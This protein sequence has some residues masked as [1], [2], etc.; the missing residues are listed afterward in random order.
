MEPPEKPD[1]NFYSQ[2]PLGA[3]GAEEGSREL[4]NTVSLK[5]PNGTVIE[6]DRIALSNVSEHFN[7]LFQDV[8]NPLQNISLGGCEAIA[9]RDDRVLLL[10]QLQSK[11]CD[12]Q[13]NM[14][15]LLAANP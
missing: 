10:N 6:V 13:V 3:L 8:P 15:A 4:K 14:V 1:I 5:F 11:L 2:Q 12:I 9:A 7:S